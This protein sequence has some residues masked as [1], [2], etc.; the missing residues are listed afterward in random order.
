MMMMMA[1]YTLVAVFGHLELLYKEFIIYIE[2]LFYRYREEAR[3]KACTVES[4]RPDQVR[5]SPATQ[6]PEHHMHKPAQL[7]V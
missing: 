5:A 1:Y 2:L 4:S 6:P 3:K 7:L